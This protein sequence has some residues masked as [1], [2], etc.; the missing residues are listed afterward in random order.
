MVRNKTGLEMT[1]LEMLLL[2]LAEIRWNSQK[3]VTYLTVGRS[4]LCY[5]AITFCE[6]N[7]ILARCSISV[8]PENVRKRQKTFGFGMEK[9]WNRNKLLN[10]EVLV[11]NPEFLLIQYK[12]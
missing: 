12:F 4:N 1:F 2:T 5:I 8:P 7:S 6:F 9:K 10:Q 11:F 3:K